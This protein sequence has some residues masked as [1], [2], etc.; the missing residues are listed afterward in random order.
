VQEQDQWIGVEDCAPAIC[1]ATPLCDLSSIY[2][3]RYVCCLDLLAIS[4]L[5]ASCNSLLSPGGTNNA[6]RNMHTGDGEPEVFVRPG[7]ARQIYRFGY[8]IIDSFWRCTTLCFLRT[9]PD[10]HHCSMPPYAKLL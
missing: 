9:N 2:I 8:A 3:L 6:L 7:N 4:F 1:H 10:I 5:F